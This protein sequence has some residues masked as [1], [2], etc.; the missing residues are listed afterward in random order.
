[1]IW[2]S[3]FMIDTIIIM[4]KLLI[5]S[6]ALSELICLSSV[7][8]GEVEWDEECGVGLSQVK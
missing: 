7:E 5:T 2:R 3:E 1:M 4:C 6:D 8:H